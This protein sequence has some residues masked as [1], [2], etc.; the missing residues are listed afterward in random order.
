ML[1]IITR[2]CFQLKN[3]NF[4]LN[5][6]ESLKNEIEINI[7]KVKSKKKSYFILSCRFM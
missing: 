3:M 5:I 1:F 2:A 7:N 6:L 4:D